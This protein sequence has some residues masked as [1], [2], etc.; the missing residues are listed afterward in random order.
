MPSIHNVSGTVTTT[1]AATLLPG[2]EFGARMVRMVTLYNPTGSALGFI[3][4]LVMFDSLKN[5]VRIRRF[6][7]SMPA[8]DSWTFGTL[9]AFIAVGP[10]QRLELVLDSSPATPVEWSLD[11]VQDP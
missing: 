7:D 10:A 11:Y 1:N 8:T 3:L 9:G 4:R 2:P 6:D 5:E